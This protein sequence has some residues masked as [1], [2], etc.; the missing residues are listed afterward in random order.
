[1]FEMQVR[2]VLVILENQVRVNK[3]YCSIIYFDQLPFYKQYKIGVLQ[4]DLDEENPI[5]TIIETDLFP[6]KCTMM[7]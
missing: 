3:Y 7:R 2:W 6:L 5:E 4:I 1:M